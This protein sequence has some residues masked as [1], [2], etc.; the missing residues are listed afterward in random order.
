LIAAYQ[1]QSQAPA[2][3][4]SLKRHRLEL[5]LAVAGLLLGSLIWL[6]LDRATPTPADIEQSLQSYVQ[7]LRSSRSLTGGSLRTEMQADVLGP[8]VERLDIHRIQQFMDYWTIDAVMQVDKIGSPSLDVP[9]R[10]RVAR[11]DGKWTVVDA[12]DLARH[13][14][15]RQ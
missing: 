10:L 8:R 12:E 7:I 11:Q 2:T 5:T 3:W 4:Q 13:A 9:I 6:H 1:W 15:L 14:P